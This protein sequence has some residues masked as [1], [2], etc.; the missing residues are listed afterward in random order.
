MQQYLFYGGVP[1]GAYEMCHRSL[2]STVHPWTIVNLKRYFHMY[3]IESPTMILANYSSPDYTHTHT[4]ILV[5]TIKLIFL[6]YMW[7]SPPTR[8]Q[9]HQYIGHSVTTHSCC[10]TM[11]L[12]NGGPLQHA[13]TVHNQKL[14]RANLINN[15]KI[16]YHESNFKK[17]TILE[18][19]AI[20]NLNPSINSQY[21][22][23]DRIQQ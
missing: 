9:K 16:L 20:K 5:Q 15:T 17:L 14:K 4:Y 11:H 7:I 22:G 18:A 21:I 13:T 23:S 3:C 12:N 1:S 19:L 10:L 2:S 8:L 6:M